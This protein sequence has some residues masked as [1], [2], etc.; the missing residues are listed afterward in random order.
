M[1][2][3]SD[4]YNLKIFSIISFITI[5]FV[6]VFMVAT[7]FLKNVYEYAFVGA[8][9]EILW[10]PSLLALFVLPLVCFYFWVKEKFSLKSLN[11]YAMLIAISTLF[12]LK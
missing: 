7:K 3:I 10:L 2:I 1:K 6:S 12:F 11:F 8:I 4:N 9:C 5:L